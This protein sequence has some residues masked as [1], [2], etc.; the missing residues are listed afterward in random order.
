MEQVFDKY[1]STLDF[2]LERQL[3][4]QRLHNDMCSIARGSELYGRISQ[5]ICQAASR[6][7]CSLFEL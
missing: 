3:P 1:M 4:C 7:S 5:H 2:P 6:R